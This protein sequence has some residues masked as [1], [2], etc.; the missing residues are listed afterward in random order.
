MSN[1]AKVCWCLSCMD[2]NQLV[3]DV[4]S[5]VLTALATLSYVYIRSCYH[6][7]EHFSP[8]AVIHNGANKIQLFNEKYT[9]PVKKHLH[10][11]NL[12]GLFFIKYC[13]MSA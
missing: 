11:Y 4:L 6:T 9:Y 12:I 7:V 13:L 2:E 10:I 5:T 1:T 8:I 3:T